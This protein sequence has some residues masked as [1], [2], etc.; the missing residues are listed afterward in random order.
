[1]VR[2]VTVTAHIDILAVGALS[3]DLHPAFDHYARLLAPL[4]DLGVREVREY[5]LRGRPE[6]DVLRDEGRRL[7]AAWPRRG[8]VVV[9]AVEGRAMDS[10]RLASAL[11][12]WLA[13]GGATF[14]VGGS[15]GLAPDVLARAHERLS[16]SRLTLPHQ[17]A[18]VVLA[19]QL[20]RAL[21]IARREPYH[22]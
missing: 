6:A 3:R 16:L 4:C 13:R 5:A 22:H 7:L 2:C 1:V 15:L 19:E 20:F 10:T 9:L 11:Q 14:V 17:L 21:K 12:G 8:V 18:R